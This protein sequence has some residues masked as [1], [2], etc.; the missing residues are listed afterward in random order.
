MASSKA[1]ILTSDP[2][3][4]NKTVHNNEFLASP[5]ATS[6]PLG[7]LASCRHAKIHPLF[8]TVPIHVSDLQSV[9]GLNT[10]RRTHARRVDQRARC[11]TSPHTRPEVRC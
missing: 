10:H 3:M 11:L 2:T 5:S 7:P 8:I 1:Y 6:T 9:T 4:C